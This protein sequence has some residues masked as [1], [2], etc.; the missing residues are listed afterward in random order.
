MAGNTYE[1]VCDAD[2]SDL[3]VSKTS[4][5]SLLSYIKEN[6]F[7]AFANFLRDKADGDEIPVCIERANK[8][9]D[10][11]SFKATMCIIHPERLRE[12]EDIESKYN[13]ICNSTAD[14]KEDV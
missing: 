11:H 7:Y 2:I 1:M 5:N 14:R 4:N 10:V 13:E 6:S 9:K 3:I 12:L 8:F